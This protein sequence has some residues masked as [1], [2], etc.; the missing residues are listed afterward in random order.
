MTPGQPP[1]IDELPRNE[2]WQEIEGG[3]EALAQL[4]ES[5]VTPG[6]F[7][8]QLLERLVGMLAAEG[9]IVWTKG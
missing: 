8:G 9:G 3:L 7:H 5:G 1:T 2:A 4:A 6:Q